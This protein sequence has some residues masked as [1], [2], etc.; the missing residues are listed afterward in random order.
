M[1]G[2][3]LWQEAICTDH[4]C[5]LPETEYTKAILSILCMPALYTTL[6]LM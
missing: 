3:Q 1:Q 5:P 4:N 6:W 2:K